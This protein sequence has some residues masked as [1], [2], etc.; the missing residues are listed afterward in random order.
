MPRDGR[1]RKQTQ[2]KRPIQSWQRAVEAEL[3][4]TGTGQ[5]NSQIALDSGQ[6]YHLYLEVRQLNTVP[7]AES[8]YAHESR[9]DDLLAGRRSS[10][11]PMAAGAGRASRFGT[12][13]AQR[14]SCLRETAQ[15]RTQ[16]PV[17]DGSLI[18]EALPAVN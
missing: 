2:P 3:V 5:S 7:C 4:C 14:A 16:R 6:I 1:W 13:T 8:K 9:G 12:V 11:A 15:A 18:R 17:V 10:R